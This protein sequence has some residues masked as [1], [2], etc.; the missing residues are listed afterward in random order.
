MDGCQGNTVITKH[1][2]TSVPDCISP[3][4][5]YTSQGQGCMGQE[6]WAKPQ[7]CVIVLPQVR[8]MDAAGEI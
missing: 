5:T 8:S 1:L 3:A 4:V 7:D 2:H 6:I